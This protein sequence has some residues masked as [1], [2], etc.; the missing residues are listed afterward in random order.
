MKKTN[1][2]TVD[3]ETDSILPLHSLKKRC[4]KY[5]FPQITTKK[6]NI[7]SQTTP[8]SFIKLCSVIFKLSR[9]QQKAK[10]MT[11]HPSYV[12]VGTCISFIKNKYSM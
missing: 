12:S 8:E 1:G 6:K 2:R 9:R 7:M 3:K 4:K 11:T 10:W 5:I